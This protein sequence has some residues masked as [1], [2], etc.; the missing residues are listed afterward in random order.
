MY[1]LSQ[2]KLLKAGPS[3]EEEQAQVR[4]RL[5]N[6]QLPNDPVMERQVHVDETWWQ[7]AQHNKALMVDIVS[8]ALFPV[9][10]TI[11]QVIYWP[12]YFF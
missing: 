4:Q 9:L 7:R 10:F 3:D 11:F 5:K 8:R 6:G 1:F 12:L 2:S